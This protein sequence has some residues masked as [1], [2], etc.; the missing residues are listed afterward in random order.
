MT[1]DP[2]WLA[3]AGKSMERHKALY[4]VLFVTVQ[5]ASSI[6][7]YYTQGQF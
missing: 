3:V 1:P 2:D 4:S 5:V 7:L 6:F